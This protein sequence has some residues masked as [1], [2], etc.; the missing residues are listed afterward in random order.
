MNHDTLTLLRTKAKIIRKDVMQ[1]L[2]YAGSGHPGGSLSAA[3]I[4]AALY[5]HEM[6]LN[7]KSPNWPQRDFF[8]LSKGHSC[9]VVYAALAESGFFSKDW[10]N[11]LRHIN[12][13]LQGHPDRKKTP[14]IEFNSGS[15]SQGFSFGLGRALAYKHTKDTNRVY[16][17]MGCGEQDEGQVWEG[18]MFGAHYKLNNVLA[19]VDYNQLQSDDTN[20]H[21]M[22]LKPLAEKWRS[23]GWN[24]FEIDGHNMEQILGAFADARGIRLKPSVIIASTI[25]GKGVS[26][27]ENVPKWHGSLAPTADELKLAMAELD[28]DQ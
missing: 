26:F 1:M 11:G 17:L 10:Y 6:R 28:N 13:A 20:D 15:L 4:V 18:A 21:I 12:G 22:M 16:I 23:F 25:K 8:V 7:P 5:F 3:D 27:M 24:V 19:I 9:P 14:G 2:H